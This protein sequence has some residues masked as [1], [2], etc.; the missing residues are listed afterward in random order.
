MVRGAAWGFRHDAAGTHAIRK[1]DG[2]RRA[3]VVLV[4]DALGL[5]LL[6]RGQRNPFQLS[7]V[8]VSILRKQRHSG[9]LPASLSTA[10]E[11]PP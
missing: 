5:C 11:I 2:E 3:G 9:A 10:T 7:A 6:Y 4:N 8:Q 1:L